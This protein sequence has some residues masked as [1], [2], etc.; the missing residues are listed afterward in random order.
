MNFSAGNSTAMLVKTSSKAMTTIATSLKKT[1]HSRAFRSPRSLR[2]KTK[3]DA[4]RLKN[5]AAASASDCKSLEVITCSSGVIGSTSTLKNH[6]RGQHEENPAERDER[7]RERDGR[8]AAQKLG[9]TEAGPALSL[10]PPLRRALPVQVVDDQPRAVVEP[11]QEEVERRRVPV[12]AEEKRRE[13]RRNQHRAPAPAESGV[14]LPR[15]GDEDVTRE[16]A[17]ESDVPALPEVAHVRGRV[18]VVEVLGRPDADDARRGYREVAVAREV[19]PD[20]D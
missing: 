14:Q 18:R 4:A 7:E 19:R 2:R 5:S 6:P 17:A 15:D 1:R 13:V 20:Y 10:Q 11:P 12:A 16:H 9:V 3:A 8:R